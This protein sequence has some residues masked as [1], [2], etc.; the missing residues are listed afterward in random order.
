MKKIFYLMVAVV[1]GCVF[2]GCS[3]DDE[4]SDYTPTYDG[5]SIYLN[6]IEQLYDNE[7]KPK[8]VPTSTEGVYT[9]YSDTQEIATDFITNLLENESWDGRN[10]TVKLGKNGESGTLNVISQNLPAGIYYE[11]VADI[12]DY[13]PYT[14]QIVT[15]ERFHNENGEGYSGGGVARLESNLQTP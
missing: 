14:L 10:V 3:K 11:I 2:T 12:V 1:M 15:E 7:G 13:T 5:V 9:V 8:F 4:P 6:A